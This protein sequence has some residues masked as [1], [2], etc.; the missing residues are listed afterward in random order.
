PI[1]ALRSP[2]S[3]ARSTP[4]TARKPP[5]LL[6][7]ALSS[8]TGWMDIGARRMGFAAARLNPSYDP[9]LAIFARRE[10]AA[11]DRLLEELVLAI[12]PELAHRRIG[13]DHRVPQLVLVVAEHL[14]LLDLL[15][16]DVLHR[17]AELVERDRPAHRV[18][19]ERGH[20][21]DEL[22]RARPLAAGL[23]HHLVNE[24]SGGVVALGEIGRD[25]VVFRAIGLHELGV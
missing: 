25:L 13:L 22:F 2:G 19:L 5:K 21:R 6:L 12:G 15:D 8:R 9:S 10:I 14:L 24:L 3:T 4:R 17:V 18:D 7:K 1:T 20:R 16:V 23:L 11:V